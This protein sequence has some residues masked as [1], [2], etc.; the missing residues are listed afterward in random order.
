MQ[1]QGKK[2]K[3]VIVGGGFAGLAVA[4]ELANQDAEVTLLDRTNHHLFQPLLYQVAT[5]VLSPAH[6]AQPIRGILSDAQNATVIMD[7][8][9]RIDKAEKVVYSKDCSYPYDYL[10]LAAG[11]RHSY[12]G[13]DA[14]ERFAPGLKSIDDAVELR[15]RILMAF[16]HAEKATLQKER[17]E[18]LTFV[19]IGAGP[20]GVEMAGAI[21]EMARF[22]L[23][24][25]F[26]HINPTDARVILLDAAPRVLPVF[27]PDL[28]EKAQK[29]LQR[30]KV[31]VRCG[32]KVLNVAERAVTLENEVIHADTIVWAAGNA[33]S[34]LGKTLGTELD[35]AGRVVVNADCSVPGHSDI[36]VLGDMA[37]FSQTKDGKPLPGVSPVAL[38]QGAWVG[39][40]IVALLK[41]KAYPERFNYFDKGSMATIGHHAAVADVHVARFD[42][43]FAW[44]AWL[45][46]HLIFLVDLRNR[47]S[48]MFHWAWAY[49]NFSRSARIIT[50]STRELPPSAPAS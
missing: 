33:A 47:V 34:P 7:E 48:V 49:V 50:S 3:V 36:F 37:S 12:F 1:N 42:G 8:V 16:E 31:D 5:A 23:R 25:D 44:L 26:R 19:I 2:P 39:K 11:A 9:V 41:G 17:E 24:R 30:M 35:R 21:T 6:I 27:A 28:S 43:Y 15:R 38:Q 40:K 29:T 13:N 20:T 4:R 14:W 45:F 18:A 22:T 32:V 46:V 10:V